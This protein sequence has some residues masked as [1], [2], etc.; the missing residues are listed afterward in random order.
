MEWLISWIIYLVVAAVVIWVV[1]KL[2]LGMTVDGFMPALIAA[3]VISIV[4][5]ILR[6]LIV[7]LL[8]IGD[9][10]GW[11]GALISLVI[12]AVVLLLS[13]RFVAGMHVNGFVGAIVAA[14]AIAVVV[15]LVNLLPFVQIGS[16]AEQTTLILQLLI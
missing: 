1:G 9:S 6:W 8:G 14:I 7:D 12:A 11:W 13:D 15:W 10:G 16:P 5:I 4:S 2:N 3:L